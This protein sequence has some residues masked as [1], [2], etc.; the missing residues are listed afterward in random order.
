M[1]LTEKYRPSDWGQVVGQSKAVATLRRLE[2][3]GELGGNNYW[4]SGQS[5]TGKTSLA[6]LIASSL[7]EP[8][9][10]E[11]LDAGDMTADKIRGI[12]KALHYRGIGARQGRV[13]IINEAHGLRNAQVTALLTL[14]EPEGGLPSYA[15]FVFTTT[16]DGESKLFADCDDASPLLS[17]CKRID[18]SRQSLAKPF[19]EHAKRIAEREGLDGRPIDFYLRLV[20]KHRQNLRAVLQDIECGAAL[21]GD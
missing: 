5:G 4:I 1:Q 17:R 6:R 14:I 8:W 11:E 18:L 13:W 19:A 10:V 20:Q 16:N 21:Q 15:A 9:N 3:N 2:V 12:E 7:A